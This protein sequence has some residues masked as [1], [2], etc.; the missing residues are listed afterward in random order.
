MGV[1]MTV[2]LGSQCDCPPWPWPRRT[3]LRPTTI[4]IIII[5]VL[6]LILLII[7][8]ICALRPPRGPLAILYTGRY[9]TAHRG[10]ALERAQFR[11][12]LRLTLSVLLPNFVCHRRA[13]GLFVIVARQAIQHRVSHISTRRRGLL[14]PLCTPPLLHQHVAHDIGD[15]ANGS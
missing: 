10:T 6:I 12:R 4:N 15:A 8:L 1:L 3:D 13:L 14:Q 2:S 11:S 5:C 9:C 7:I